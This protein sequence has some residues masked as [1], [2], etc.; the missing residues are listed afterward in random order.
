MLQ[1]RSYIG[2]GNESFICGNCGMAVPPATNGSVRNH[3]PHCLYSRHLDIAPGDRAA[4]CRGLM[5]PVG[6]YYNSRKGYQVIHR[7]L[8]CGEVRRN[9]L[10]ESGE[11]PDDPDLVCLL[12]QHMR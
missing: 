2:S 4:D 11:V 7:C 3:C 5:A 6:L 9:R 8:D 1:Q 12:S 10:V